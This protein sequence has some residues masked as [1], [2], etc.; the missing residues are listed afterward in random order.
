MINQ[1]LS[2]EDLQRIVDR[3][4]PAWLRSRRKEAQK[5]ILTYR[6][7]KYASNVGIAVVYP[8]VCTN[9]IFFIVRPFLKK[10]LQWYDSPK[11]LGIEQRAYRPVTW[12][13]PETDCKNC[14]FYK[15][16]PLKNLDQNI[17]NQ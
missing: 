7:C 6:T 15:T 12:I 14:P 10:E 17:F 2:H 13:D 8:E 11:L 9:L 1:N 3:E 4:T 5:G 16:K